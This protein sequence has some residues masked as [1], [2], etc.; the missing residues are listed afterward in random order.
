MKDSGLFVLQKHRY[1][2][3]ELLRSYLTGELAKMADH[4]AEFLHFQDS[5][6][7]K[8]PGNLLFFHLF[9]Q[10]KPVQD[11]L[12]LLRHKRF[13]YRGEIGS[14]IPRSVLV[15]RYYRDIFYLLPI[16]V[17]E[18]WLLLQLSRPDWKCLRMLLLVLVDGLYQEPVAAYLRLTNPKLWLESEGKL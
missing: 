18:N 9:P 6:L 1:N 2:L 4:I 8:R 12:Q 10:Y 11:R 7:I 14:T 5:R 15:H 3:P 17:G 13:H 16:P